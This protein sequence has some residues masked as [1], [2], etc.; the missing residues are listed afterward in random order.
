M[1]AAVLTDERTVSIEKRTT[2]SVSSDEV[3][4]QV[5][6]CGVC[7]TDYHMYHGTFP[8]EHPL[9]PGHES[10]GEVIEVGTGVTRVEVGDRVAINPSIPC[11]Q[12]RAC[13]RGREN[14]CENF[15]SLGGAGD[16]ILDG[17]FAEYIHVPAASVEPIGNLSYR[18]AAC[19]EPLACCIHAVEQTDLETG[20]TVVIIG[21]GPIGLLLV[22]SFK[23]SGSGTVIVS[24][25]IAERR[26][27]ALSLG[28]DHAV[29]PTERDLGTSLDSLVD[30]V[31]VAVEAVGSPETI[32][33]TIDV[34][35]PGGTTLVFGV[36]PQDSTVEIN[37]FDM[38]YN[39]LELVGTY[40]LTPQSFL[41]AVTFLKEDRITIDP[42]ITDEY[43]LD[44]LEHAFKQMDESEGLKK[45]I[46]PQKEMYEGEW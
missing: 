28:A 27:L 40:S 14:L 5:G 13:K 9:V 34:T 11:N 36:P 17:A 31:N 8:I 20:E 43:A 3:L 19:A 33:Q 44:R 25:P 21:T 23:A 16:C 15:V 30:E 1:K 32:R 42:L 18:R 12:C 22:Q 41:R 24:E 26:D 35:S 45:I 37:P 29:D 6:V 46:Y 2:P 38:F 10:A 7:M 4:V 39:E